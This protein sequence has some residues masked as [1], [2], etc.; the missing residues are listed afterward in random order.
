[1]RIIS[2]ASV[3]IAARGWLFCLGQQPHVNASSVESHIYHSRSTAIWRNFDLVDSTCRN[4]VLPRSFIRSICRNSLSIGVQPLSILL[5]A[6]YIEYSTLCSARNKSTR[7]TQTISNANWCIFEKVR[8]VRCV[9][10]LLHE[11]NS[12]ACLRLTTYLRHMCFCC[13]GSYERNSSCTCMY[14]FVANSKTF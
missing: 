10:L 5:Y 13:T 9:V 2:P 11:D 8:D 4:L 7:H 12:V 3:V 6:L 1:M 14:V